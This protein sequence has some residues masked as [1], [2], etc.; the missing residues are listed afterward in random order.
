MKSSYTNLDKVY[1]I[2][3]KHCIYSK[4]E[5]LSGNEMEKYNLISSLFKDN[6]ITFEQF[7]NCIVKLNLSF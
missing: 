5:K 3:E 4:E 2:M 1:E 7:E 6:L